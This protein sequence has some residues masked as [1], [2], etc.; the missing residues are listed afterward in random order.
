MKNDNKPKGV[1]HIIEREGQ[2]SIWNRVGTA[3]V[4]RDGSLNILLN[5]LPVDGKLH[6]RD[7][8]QEEEE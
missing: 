8:R 3:F 2:R 4:N 7:A 1:Y 6:V 5:S